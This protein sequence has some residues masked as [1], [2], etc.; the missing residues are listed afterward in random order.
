MNYCSDERIA[1]TLINVS[2]CN[3]IPIK[4]LLDSINTP[5]NTFDGFGFSEKFHFKFFVFIKKLGVSPKRKILINVKYLGKLE[6]VMVLINFN[7]SILTDKILTQKETPFDYCQIHIKKP[8]I[9]VT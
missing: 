9:F 4:T 8:K 5:D 1:F 3:M 2:G 6:F 7:T